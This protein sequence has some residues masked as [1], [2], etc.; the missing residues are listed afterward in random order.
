MS[1]GVRSILL[2]FIKSG[3]DKIWVADPAVGLVKYTHEEF[4]KNWASTVT[5]GKPVG[6]VLI[7]EPTPALFEKENEQETATWIQ[8]P[9]QIF[10]SL[11]KI[12]FSADS[13]S[14]SW[15]LHSAC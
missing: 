8:I 4:M 14:A 7:I 11:Q 1:T 6:L 5:D 2:L 3:K 12:F 15:K 9:F 10:P 13:W